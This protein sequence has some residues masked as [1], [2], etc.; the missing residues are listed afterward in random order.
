MRRT[1]IDK[2]LQQAHTAARRVL[3]MEPDSLDASML[4]CLLSEASYLA[5]LVGSLAELLTRTTQHETHAVLVGEGT[6]GATGHQVCEQLRGGGYRG[7]LILLSRQRDPAVRAAVLSRGADDF[8]VKPYDPHELVA[9]IQAV[10]RRTF[11]SDRLATGDVIRVGGAEL[12]ISEMRFT[13]NGRPPV[14]LTPTEMRL[15]ECLM[16][17]RAITITRD[18]LIDRAWPH[19]ILAASNRID[20]YIARLR[21]KIEVDPMHP[22]YIQTVRGLGYVFRERAAEPTLNTHTAAA[23]QGGQAIIASANPA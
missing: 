17:N 8:V 11:L 13:G 16:R 5:V 15:L 21:K 19:D 3:V 14:Y 18:R 20:V 23:S 9:R 6:H 7:P 1:A 22:E 10:A 4:M 2:R 12:A